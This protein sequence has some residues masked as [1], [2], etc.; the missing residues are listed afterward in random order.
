MQNR[1][2]Y[3]SQAPIF[4]NF[5]LI[6]QNFALYFYPP[7]FQKK[8]LAKLAQPQQQFSLLSLFE[9]FEFTCAV[10]ATLRAGVVT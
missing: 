7:I 4:P 5:H 2:S 3:S 9:K 1:L 6:F 10:S 8:L